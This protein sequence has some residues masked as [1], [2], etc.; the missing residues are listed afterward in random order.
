MQKFRNYFIFE[1]SCQNESD[2]IFKPASPPP[3]TYTHYHMNV[4]HLGRISTPCPSREARMNQ[5]EF[6][7]VNVW[8]MSSSPT[9]AWVPIER[10]GFPVQVK[11]ASYR[12]SGLNREIALEYQNKIIQEICNHFITFLLHFFLLSF[13][14]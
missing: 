4:T 13:S 9:C 8:L 2:S 1:V 14:W 12:G 3:Y 10:T 5:K 6:M 11:I 7:A